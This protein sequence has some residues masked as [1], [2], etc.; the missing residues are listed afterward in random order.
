[1][2]L[3]NGLAFPSGCQSILYW[4]KTFTSSKRVNLQGILRIHYDHGKS[5]PQAEPDQTEK[6]YK[7]RK[8]ING[9]NVSMIANL[10]FIVVVG[11]GLGTAE[12]IRQSHTII[13]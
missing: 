2:S 3:L 5:I 7:P 12:V 8:R 13:F 9:L 4:N 1:L 6:V 10:A 11:I